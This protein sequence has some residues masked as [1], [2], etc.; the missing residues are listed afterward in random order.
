MEKTQQQFQDEIDARIAS[1][2]QRAEDLSKELNI[3]VDFHTFTEREDNYNLTGNVFVAYT[4]Q[5]HVLV[6]ARA[7]D[8]LIAN[9]DFEAGTLLWSSCFIVEH[10]SKEIENVDKYKLGLTGMLGKYLEIQAPD[11]KKN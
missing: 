10:S 8:L 2:K 4:K 11:V 1:F 3:K 9:K 5:P 6:A 7:M